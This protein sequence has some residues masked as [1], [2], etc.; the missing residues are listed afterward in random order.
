M[1]A[2]SVSPKTSGCSVSSSP[3]TSSLIQA[4]PNTSRAMCAVVTA[5]F[6]EWQPAVLGSTRTPSSRISD[7]KPCPA[8][9]PPDS[10]RS[11][12]V[13]TSAPRGA[14]RRAQHRR[15]G[16]ARRAQQQARAQRGAI[17][18][19]ASAPLHRRQHLEAIAVA[20]RGA[21][22][23]ARRR[24]TRRSPRSRRALAIAELARA[25]R[26]AAPRAIS[27]QAPLTRI[28]IH[29]LRKMPALQQH[30]RGAARERRGEQEAMPVQAIHVQRVAAH[31][32][33]RQVVRKG[34]AHRRCRSRGPAPRRRPGA[35]RRRPTA[36]RASSAR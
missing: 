31:R 35:A 22:A 15:R 9:S 13:T 21:R 1:R 33:P 3:I 11:D 27:R 34:R 26:P 20:Q 10:R 12:T 19:A 16:I 29:H 8:R 6:T 7:Q 32:E 24:R 4:V 30:L 2:A 5:S 28:F 14:H 36:A 23:R 18:L 17:E 25:P